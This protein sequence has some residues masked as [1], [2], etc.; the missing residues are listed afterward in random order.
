MFVYS[1]KSSKLKIVALALAVVLA[2]VGLVFLASKN[3]SPA[4]SDGAVSLKAGSA[5]ERTAFL[6]QFGWKITEDPMEVCEVIIPAEFDAAYTEY[7]ALQQKQGLDLAPYAS[8]RA[9]RWTY[10]VLNYP[11]YENRPGLVQANLLVYEGKVIG[12][13]ICSAELNGFMQGFN[14]PQSATTAAPATTTAPATTLLTQTTAAVT[15]AP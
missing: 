9:K 5:A 13:D 11:G 8:L 4:A 12:G 14:Y 6:S 7:N 3:K 10:E 15:K 2:I 1:V